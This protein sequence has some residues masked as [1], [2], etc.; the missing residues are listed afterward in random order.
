MIIKSHYETL[1]QTEIKFCLE[2]R[3]LEI[4]WKLD[5]RLFACLLYYR[6]L[7]NQQKCNLSTKENLIFI[8]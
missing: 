6:I 7:K 8:N 5:I 1:I 4:S 3:D 2:L